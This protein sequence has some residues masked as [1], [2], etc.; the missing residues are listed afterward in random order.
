MQRGSQ[1]KYNRKL[2]ETTAMKRLLTTLLLLAGLTGPA[3]AQLDPTAA[4]PPVAKKVPKA[5]V[6][7]GEERIDNY[8]WL[9]EKSNPQVIAYLE[10]EN[11]Y[12]GAIMKPTEAFQEVLYKE[13]LGRIKQTDLTVPFQQG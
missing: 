13:M 1:W 10:A 11:A 3:A 5:T 8:Y 4:Q 7:H 6:L 12:T 9:R 2:V